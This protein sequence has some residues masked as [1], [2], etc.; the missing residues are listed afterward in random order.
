MGKHILIIDDEESVRKS[1]V[2]SLEGEGYEVETAAS[3]EEG[4]RAIKRQR[5]D[6]IFLDLKMPGMNGVDT[7]YEIRKIDTDVH[8]Y[9]ITAFL[10]EFLDLLN[11]AVKQGVKFEI[12]KKP[13]GSQQI[14]TLVK[15]ELENPSAY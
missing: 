5:P 13:I 15:S 11:A 9:V 1:F 2:L 12:L 8:V 7:L 10:K 4:V 14:R 6:L 3:G